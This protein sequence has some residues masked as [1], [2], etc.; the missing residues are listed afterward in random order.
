MADVAVGHQHAV[1]AD[2]GDAVGLRRPVDR[3]AFAQHGARADAHPARCRHG[4]A[5]LR[6]AA[7]DRE[8]VDDDAVA[9]FAAGADHGVGA[10]PAAGSDCHVRLDHGERA[11]FGIGGQDD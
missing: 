9:E 5:H 8:A 11:D 2:A 4:R 10:D 7:D 1:G 3:D 6:R